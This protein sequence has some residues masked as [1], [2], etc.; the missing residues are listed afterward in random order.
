MGKHIFF[1]KHYKD[2]TKIP[3]GLTLF[4][5]S[6]RLFVLRLLYCPNKIVLRL[7]YCPN[8]IVLRLLYCPNIACT[9][10]AF[11]DKVVILSKQTSICKAL[12]IVKFGW[13]TLK[14]SMTYWWEQLRIDSNADCNLLKQTKIWTLC[15]A[16]NIYYEAIGALRICFCKAWGPWGPILSKMDVQYFIK[17]WKCIFN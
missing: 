12:F 1:L 10:Q 6:R 15:C 8:I 9:N 2:F 17:K 7:L 3:V 5:H 16:V 14:K 4:Q 11:W 13:N